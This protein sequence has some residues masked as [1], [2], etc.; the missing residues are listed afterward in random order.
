MKV[1]VD[2]AEWFPVLCLEVA[3]DESADEAEIR[4]FEAESKYM[5]EADVPEEMLERYAE[6]DK[7]WGKMQSEL[8]RYLKEQ[9]VQ[10]R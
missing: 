7:A 1:W 9:G 4:E 2:E 5:L 6:V 3:P 10:I 8:R